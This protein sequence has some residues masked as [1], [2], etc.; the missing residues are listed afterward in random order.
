VRGDPP[1]PT[2]PGPES[3]QPRGRF[4][5]T[6]K[7][8]VSQVSK[9]RPGA[10]S[11]F[12]E[13]GG[14][15][16]VED[17]PQ[18]S[19]EAFFRKGFRFEVGFKDQPG[20]DGPQGSD[21]K[22]DV[23]PLGARERTE[24]ILVVAF[25]GGGPGHFECF[26]QPFFRF[27]VA[28]GE[29]FEFEREDG[30]G[31]VVHQADIE[32]AKRFV[33]LF[34]IGAM[35]EFAQERIDKFPG[36]LLKKGQE[37]VFLALEVGVDGS[38]AA[39][40]GGGDLVQLSIFISVP[41]EDL[42]GGIEKAGLSLLGAKLLSAQSLHG[43]HT[44]RSLPVELLLLT[45][46]LTG[47]YLLSMPQ[48]AKFE[49]L[50]ATRKEKKTA[51][52]VI[53]GLAALVACGAAAGWAVYAGGYESTDNAQ[54]DGHLNVVSSRIG[55]TAAAVYVTDNQTVE[56]GQ[57]L[58]DL[59]RSE[60]KVTYA[61][62]KAQYDQ[63]VAQL[64]SQRPGVAITQA[65]NVA[66]ALTGDAQV[67]QARAGFAAAS[68]D[69]AGATA[70]LAEAEAIRSRDGAELQRYEQLF[71]TGTISRQDYE[72]SLS[73]A[74]SADANVDAARANVASAE[75]LV[76]QRKAEI[77]AQSARRE[78]T[79]RTAPRQLSIKEA[80]LATAEA[81]VEAA[82]AQLNRA[83]LNLSFCHI[84]SPVRGIVTERS[85]E[86]GNRVSEG[87]PLMMIVATGDTWVTA[88]FKETQLARMQPG[89]RVKVHADALKKNFEGIVEG[90]PA[91]TGARSSVL[92]PENATGN[93]IKVVQRMPVRIRLNANQ[94]SLDRLR[95][96]MSVEATVWLR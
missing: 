3:V 61:Q 91:I 46:K 68:Q 83:E 35:G 77:D 63:A 64:N 38:L 79:T 20:D 70:K 84:V 69:L 5:S 81:N 34:A 14:K 16:G 72:R 53:A 44:I 1:F 30:P 31:A 11:F 23:G 74:H 52:L 80:E 76:E 4:G 25:I 40:G 71:Q 22:I 50:P 78:Q 18:D 39:A 10:P 37:Q 90:I 33:P 51:R 57:P 62:A 60:Q 65:D 28:D 2:N 82:A 58:A 54:I 95:P 93:Y 75:K 86:I 94:D 7:G 45:N 32:L 17:A 49:V 12:L 96:G 85:A 26:A 29:E 67:A 27:G 55:G 19:A 87:Q 42:L 41:E 6:P 88:N 13:L 59:D 48:V 43:Q 24:Q 47:Q 21:G 36:P 73:A 9:S 56:A 89:Q 92:P 8:R 15:Q 66:A